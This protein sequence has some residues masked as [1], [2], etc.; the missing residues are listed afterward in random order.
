[1]GR[2]STYAKHIQNFMESGLIDDTANL[3]VEGREVLAKTPK[4]MLNPKLSQAIEAACTTKISAKNEEAPWV[5]LAARI[6]NALPAEIK[7]A[8]APVLQPEQEVVQK[9]EKTM[10]TER[11]SSGP[12]MA[13]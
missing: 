11:R 2:P 9:Q 4:V 1:M 3:T 13:Y 5:D 7:T 12:E 8:I 10:E 6:I